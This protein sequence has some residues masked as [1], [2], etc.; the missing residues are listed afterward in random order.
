[1]SCV[2]GLGFLS[3]PGTVATLL[4]LVLWTGASRAGLTGE[5]GRVE[6]V[7]HQAS[8]L[9]P[10]ALVEARLMSKEK[11]RVRLAT[12][13][14]EGFVLRSEAT[15]GSDRR[16]QFAEAK[17]VRAVSGR[18]INTAGIIGALTVVVVVTLAFLSS[19]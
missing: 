4:V 16:V 12:V 7:R 11:L 5:D 8:G 13:D 10:G 17:P 6:R 9:R 15:G 19:I 18:R 2:T 1:M 14:A 3:Q